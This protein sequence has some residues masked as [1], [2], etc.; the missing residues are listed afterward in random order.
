MDVAGHQESGQLPAP[1]RAALRRWMVS[2]ILFVV[3]IAFLVVLG[4]GLIVSA[5]FSAVFPLGGETPLV[6][7]VLLYYIAYAAGPAFVFLP[8][9]VP[10]ALTWRHPRRIVIFR[11]FNTAAESGVLRSIATRDL[12]RYGHVFTLADGQIR[13]SWLIRVPALLGQIGLLHFRPRRIDSDRRLEALRRSLKRV[14]RL[15]LNWLVSARK[16]F[17]VRSSDS[18]WQACVALLLEQ[19]DVVVMDISSFSEAMSWELREC[20]R[21]GL[22]DRTILLSA[23]KRAEESRRA[24]ARLAGYVHVDTVTLFLYDT[25]GL[26]EPDGFIRRVGE[27]CA[28][29]TIDR[30]PVS[31]LDAGLTVATTLA[32]GLMLAGAGVVATAPYVWPGL[33]A[34]YSPFRSQVMSASFV[35]RQPDLLARILESDPEWTRAR[36]VAQVADDGSETALQALEKMGDEKDV[37]AL[38]RVIGDRWVPQDTTKSWWQRTTPPGHREQDALRALLHR[39]GRPALEPLLHALATAPRVPFDDA[40]YE[41]YVRLQASDLPATAFEPLLTAPS[42]GARFIGGLE[43][44]RRNEMRAI[45]ILLEMLRSGAGTLREEDFLTA[46]EGRPGLKDEWIE[47]YVF[48]SDDA[49]RHA[50]RLAIRGYR[51]ASLSA[52]VN[53]APNGAGQRLMEQLVWTAQGED[54]RLAGSARSMLTGARPDWIRSLLADADGFVRTRAGYALAERRDPSFLPTALAASKERGKC[55]TIPFLKYDCYPYEEDAATA[56][57]RLRMKWHAGRRLGVAIDVAD[58]PSSVIAS[59]LQLVATTG[60][61]A[62]AARLVGDMRPASRPEDKRALEIVAGLSD[63]RALE[64]VFTHMPRSSRAVA[65]FLSAIADGLTFFFP[66]D[67][68][69]IAR[70]ATRDDLAAAWEQTGHRC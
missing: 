48:G 36:L 45:P 26:Y 35:A 55:E 65:P 59:M 4:A 25:E 15:N 38:V 18:H 17:P 69:G 21:R 62:V 1:D 33:T 60:D 27:I 46:F 42:S 49:A 20:H 50:A 37:E 47:P 40:L 14:W 8:V 68:C 39:L 70:S 28:S 31:A 61:T 58:L 54:A 3:G 10:F 41:G 16:I 2:R 53:R 23:A 22:L 12:S 34:Q 51:G 9:L 43:F 44:A 24:V 6:A 67:V 11:R 64:L 56:I 57:D 13:R 63:P 66:A 7:Y 29:G 30:R 32:L 19:A 5:L 52:I